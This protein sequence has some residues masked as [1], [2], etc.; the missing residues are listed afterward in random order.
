MAICF[1]KY[2]SL[3]KNM[4]YKKF[5]AET[6]LLQTWSTTKKS[7]VFDAYL[8]TPS[9]RTSSRRPPFALKMHQRMSAQTCFWRQ[10]FAPV[11][12]N[13]MGFRQVSDHSALDSLIDKVLSEQPAALADF[14]AGQSKAMRFLSGKAIQASGGKTNP[15]IMRE[16]LTKKPETTWKGRGFILKRSQHKTGIYLYGFLIC[17]FLLILIFFYQIEYESRY[18]RSSW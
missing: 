16:L 14:W 9:P 1:P 7:G 5:T 10:N 15:R 3:K 2:T 12:W 4:G 13:S 8:K 18:F 17:F 11:F 6:G